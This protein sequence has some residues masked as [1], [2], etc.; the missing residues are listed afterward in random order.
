MSINRPLENGVLAVHLGRS[1]RAA[2]HE[3][4]HGAVLA[5]IRNMAPIHDRRVRLKKKR[6]GGI[7]GVVPEMAKKVDD[8]AA[9]LLAIVK[10]APAS[11]SYDYEYGA[12]PLGGAGGD[13]A[14]AV[15][16]NEVVVAVVNTEIDAEVAAAT[17]D[18]G[19]DGAGGEAVEM[20]AVDPR[21]AVLGVGSSGIGGEGRGRGAS[22][23]ERRMMR[24]EKLTMTT[25]ERSGAVEQPEDNTA[26]AEGCMEVQSERRGIP[27]A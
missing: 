21:V 10:S 20:T 22:G 4:V 3:A 12:Y 25:E 14:V 17:E 19:D 6:S 26:A 23:Y 11:D 8:R 15:T 27:L 24:T 7:G 5:D 1:D 18:M 13:S 2:V 16:V 9:S